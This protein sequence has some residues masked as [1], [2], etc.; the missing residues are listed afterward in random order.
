MKS[1]RHTPG[2]A[3]LL[4][5]AALGFAKA[6]AVEDISNESRLPLE[7]LQLFVQIFDQIRTAYVEEVDDATLFDNAIEGLL[8]GL[9]PHSSYLNESDFDDLQESTTGEFGGL[10]IEVGMEG[11][12][13]R[14][15]API[16]DTPAYRAGI[17]TGDL[18][19]KLSAD[20]VAAHIADGHGAAF[21]P[22]GRTFKEWVAFPER[23]EARWREVLEEAYAFSGGSGAA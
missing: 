1:M 2:I 7:D 12:L 10:G 19:I 17:Q 15:I 5:T 21:A 13:I 11:G 3:A 23:D 6:H 18:I 20:R 22:N 4:L 14:V 9:D 8:G 16:D